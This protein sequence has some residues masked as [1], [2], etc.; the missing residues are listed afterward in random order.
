MCK[1]SVDSILGSAARGQLTLV[2]KKVRF[3]LS[4]NS[5][6]EYEPEEFC[7]EGEQVVARALFAIVVQ[8]LF[9]TALFSG[10][11]QGVFV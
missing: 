8:G 4:Q 9:F 11:L 7:E 10:R 2:R 5:V 3:D 1:A 6:L